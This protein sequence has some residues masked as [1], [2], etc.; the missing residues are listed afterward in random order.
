ML[1]SSVPPAPDAAIVISP[2]SDPQLLVSL[3]V[4]LAITGESITVTVISSV[5]VQP[6]PFAT[7]TV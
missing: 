6:K 4:T 7:V 2:S 1:Y 3:D 5:S